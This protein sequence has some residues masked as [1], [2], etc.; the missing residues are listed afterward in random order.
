MFR[1]IIGII[2]ELGDSYI[3]LNN[4]SIGYLIF[5]SKNTLDKLKIGDEAKIYTYMHVR[6]DEMSLYGFNT[7]NELDLYKLLLSV[8]KVGPKVG[9]A[10]LSELSPNELKKAILMEDTKPL[11]RASGVGSKTAKRIILELK[12]KIDSDILTG[13][14]YEEPSTSNINN[15]EEAM[16]AL[17]TL[18]YSKI[19]INTAFKKIDSSLERTE[20]LIKSALKQL[21]KR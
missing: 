1:Y 8:S 12:D 3:V 13:E 7:M 18:G 14:T 15:F 10:L 16:I 11:S 4:N 19:E 20:D 6:E 2:D 21:A 5:S 9:L 17:Q